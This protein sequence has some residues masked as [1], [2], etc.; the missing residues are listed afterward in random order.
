MS[1]HRPITVALLSVGLLASPACDRTAPAPPAAPVPTVERPRLAVATPS[2]SDEELRLAETVAEFYATLGVALSDPVASGDDPE[3]IVAHMAATL[4]PMLPGV[5]RDGAAYRA[6]PEERRAAV[7]RVA[8]EKD[9]DSLRD[10]LQA[11]G[12]FT[13]RYR[14]DER[15]GDFRP[16]IREV[17][18]SWEAADGFWVL[19]G[20]GEEAVR[21]MKEWSE[22]T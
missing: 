14:D 4:S 6:L 2:Y 5:E 13:D 16:I 17:F 1:A 21:E 7:H 15:L 12:R 11:T 18:G 19:E 3:A 9:P 10:L 20:M 8:F 22:S